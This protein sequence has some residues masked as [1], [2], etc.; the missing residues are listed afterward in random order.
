VGWPLERVPK[1]PPL[2]ALLLVALRQAY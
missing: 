1:P 2:A